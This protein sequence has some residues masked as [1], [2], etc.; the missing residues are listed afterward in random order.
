M[1]S[2][3][4]RHGDEGQLVAKVVGVVGLHV[5]QGW[6]RLGHL[7]QVAEGV[8]RVLLPFPGRIGH[9]HGVAF[10]DVGGGPRVV[11]LGD[12]HG[13][14]EAIVGVDGPI[15]RAAGGMGLG[16]A[17]DLA[18]RGAAAGVVFGIDGGDDG[19]AVARFDLDGPAEAVHGGFGPAIS[20]RPMWSQHAS[21]VTTWREKRDLSVLSRGSRLGQAEPPALLRGG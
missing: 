6:V 17:L 7:D 13:A 3:P 18:E 9:R 12:A 16:D 11:R 10:I 5:A 15:D 20:T 2:G 21:L 1:G 14:A 19:C 4:A 8:G